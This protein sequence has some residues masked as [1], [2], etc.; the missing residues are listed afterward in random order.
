MKKLLL[1]F[2]ATTLFV[3]CNEN[4]K[5]EDKKMPVEQDNGIGDGAPSLS[6]AFAQGV[7]KTHNK[8][9]FLENN[10]IS[11]D[12]A[13]NFNGQERLNGTYTM[14]TNSSKIKFESKDGKTLI[15]NGENVSLSPK[16]ATMKMA[17]FD[18]FTWPYFMAM[19]FKL[20]D[21]GTQWG[22]VQQV[23]ENGK[24]FSKAKL[25]FKNDVGDTSNDWYEVYVDNDTNLLNYASYIV[26]FGKGV[27]KA[28]EKPHAILYENYQVV[29]GIAISDTWKFYNWSEEKGLYGEPIGDATLSNIQFLESAD[30]T[31]S[32]DA[33]NVEAPK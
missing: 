8:E 21:P 16:D 26:T 14:R 12:I 29:D 32:K 24:E 5:Q 18:I 9:A 15:Y 10:N 22:A 4:K 33:K 13:L 6:T 28:E 20:T 19:P 30:Y 1:L 27:E 23:T 31:V 17:R 25:S 7:E 11:F 3:S 2:A